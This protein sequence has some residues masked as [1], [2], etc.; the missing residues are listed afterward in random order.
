MMLYETLSREEFLP[1][2]CHLGTLILSEG[3]ESVAASAGEIDGTDK[4]N[5]YQNYQGCEQG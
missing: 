2:N 1:N 5:R 4:R 3:R